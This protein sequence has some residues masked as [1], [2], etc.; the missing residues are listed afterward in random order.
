MI[1][2]EL[3]LYISRDSVS[4]T[5]DADAPHNREL[6]ISS[7]MSVED[8]VSTI[9]CSKYLPAIAGG[10]AT[11]SVVSNLPLA[12]I[13]QQWPAPKMLS[14][15]PTCLD[16]LNVSGNMIKVHINYHAQQNP[17]LVFDVLKKLRLKAP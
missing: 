1:N 13:A 9:F 4:A 15:I 16:E 10:M 6:T 5:D 14:L 12:I 7:D 2:K 3:K 11:W 17:D 8:I